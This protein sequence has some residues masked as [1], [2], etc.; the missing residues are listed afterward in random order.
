MRPDTG[1][2]LSELLHQQMNEHV[3]TYKAA[4]EEGRLQERRKWAVVVAVHKRFRDGTP[5]ALSHA[6]DVA[7]ENN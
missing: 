3:T 7:A 5:A 1:L 2:D 6:I 4:M